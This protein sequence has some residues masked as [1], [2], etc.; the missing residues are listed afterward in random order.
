MNTYGGVEAFLTSAP[1]GSDWSASRSVRFTLRERARCIHSI[2]GWLSPRAGLDAMTKTKFPD[3]S[4]ISFCHYT[5]G[6]NTSDHITFI[7]EPTRIGNMTYKFMQR[8]QVSML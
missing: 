5:V 1:D 8:K 2:G 3:R 4:S 6:A 7:L